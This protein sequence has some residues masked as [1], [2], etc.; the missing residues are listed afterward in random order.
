MADR[1]TSAA[2]PTGRPARTLAARTATAHRKPDGRRPSL[3][4]ALDLSPGQPFA[5]GVRTATEGGAL[6]FGLR[7][8]G[9][10]PSFQGFIEL[11]RV[12]YRLRPPV[13]RGLFVFQTREDAPS[14]WRRARR[15]EVLAPDSTLAH[16]SGREIAG[17]GGTFSP[18]KLVSEDPQERREALLSRTWAGSLAPRESVSLVIEVPA[19]PD[20]VELEGVWSWC[21]LARCFDLLQEP[22]AALVLPTPPQAAHHMRLMCLHDTID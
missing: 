15:G 1:R 17:D 22:P 5:V 13:G 10:A 18:E 6:A 8:T 19:M 9:L 12:T 4:S 20:G 21:L 16:R 11:S 2:R 14:F 3:Y 7:N